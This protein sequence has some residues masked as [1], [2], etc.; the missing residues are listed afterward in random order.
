MA[1][2]GRTADRQIPTLRKL[3][4][5]APEL[6]RFLVEAQPFARA[7]RESVDDLGG[8]ADAGLAAV[9]ESKEEIAE[10]AELSGEA[11]RLAKPLRQFLQTI[12]DR[13][14]STDDDPLAAELAPPE[15]DKTAYRQGQG[16]TGMES[17]WN[18]IYWQTLGINAYDEFGHLLR[19]VAFTGGPCSPYSA[20]P[21]QKVVDE[22]SS[23]LG[24][25]QPG[26]LGQPDPTEGPEPA[27]E[28]MA[29]AEARQPA[30]PQT[31]HRGAGE[32]E[33]PKLPGQ[34]DIS[35]PQVVVPD[36]VRE[37][38]ERLREPLP[39]GGALP[40][41]APGVPAPPATELPQELLDYLLAP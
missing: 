22:C 5:A 21:T 39:D 35:R 31:E 28:R 33:A 8:A 23:W 15:P 12:D 6:E 14:R 37:L 20:N 34:P 18:Y 40:Q 27:A 26:V 19:I 16:F 4:N 1:E 32:P 7:S 13:R 41:T 17:F 24:P 29:R 38:L 30:R 25:T 3:G 9:R 36:E 2:L 10:L 11:P